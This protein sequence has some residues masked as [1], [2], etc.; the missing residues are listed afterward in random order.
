MAT[1]AL[2]GSAIYIRNKTT[3]KNSSDDSADGLE[4]LRGKTDKLI[5]TSVSKPPPF[6]FKWPQDLPIDDGVHL[7]IGDFNSHSTNWRYGNTKKDGE[8]VE[9]WALEKNLVLLNK[10][11]DKPSYLSA[12]W[13]KVCNPDL[14][15]VSSRHHQNFQKSVQ[16][17]ISKSEHRPITVH[18]TRVANPIHHEREATTQIQLPESQVG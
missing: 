12:R 3:V 18:L 16:D 2:H 4:I 9:E 15:F 14:A 13:R 6:P 7:V 1:P 17:P 11:K 5:I 10:A 8:L